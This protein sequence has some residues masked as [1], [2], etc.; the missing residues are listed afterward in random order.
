MSGDFT[1]TISKIGAAGRHS[2]T[3]REAPRLIVICEYGRLT[4]PALR[5]ALGD[6]QEVI[7]GRGSQRSLARQGTTATLSVP[8][9]E[10]SRKH[11]VVRR[12]RGGWEVADLGSM[13]GRRCSPP[14][15]GRLPRPL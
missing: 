8:D 7:V 4:V 9:D 15:R 6:L 13:S 3:N 2:S 14:A 11:L 12:Q 10:T 5:V 1:K